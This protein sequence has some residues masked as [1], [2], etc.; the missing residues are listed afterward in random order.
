MG[1]Q[2]LKDNLWKTLN[3]PVKGIDGAAAAQ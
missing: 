3:E 1:L 2:Q